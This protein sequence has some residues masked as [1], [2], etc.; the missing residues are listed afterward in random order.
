MDN[1][2]DSV[3]VLIGR[4]GIQ[5]KDAEHLQR[6]ISDLLARPDR[7]AELG[8]MARAAVTAVRGAGQ[9]DVDHLVRLLEERRAAGQRAA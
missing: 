2:H 6:V 7:M 8:S 1:F 5:V 9:R 3:Q 4:G